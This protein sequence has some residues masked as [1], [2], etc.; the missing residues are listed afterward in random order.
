[1]Y[2]ST[3]CIMSLT[4]CSEDDANV[5]EWSMRQLGLNPGQLNSD[6]L[7]VMVKEIYTAM[8]GESANAQIPGS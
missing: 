4:G 6:D 5:I 3:P 2:N 1:M 7:K 8:R